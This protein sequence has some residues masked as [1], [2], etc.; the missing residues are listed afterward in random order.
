MRRLW[1]VA[2]TIVEDWGGLA[3]ITNRRFEVLATSHEDAELKVTDHLLR[4]HRCAVPET[5][6]D[7]REI[8]ISP[9]LCDMNAIRDG[10]YPVIRCVD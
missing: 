7:L 9:V 2:V 3:A 10:A 5:K 8:V 1:S 4:E 6:F